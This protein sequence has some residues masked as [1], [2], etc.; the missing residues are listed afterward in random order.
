MLRRYE[1]FSILLNS[2]YTCKK[3]LSFRSQT[4]FLKFSFHVLERGE[5]VRIQLI[6]QTQTSCNFSVFSTREDLAMSKLKAEC[7]AGCESEHIMV[8]RPSKDPGG[9]LQFF[10]LQPGS[11]YEVVITSA[12]FEDY[13]APKNIGFTFSFCTS[14]W[15]F[16]IVQLKV[17][18]YEQHALF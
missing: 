2:Q 17:L 4:I 15:N 13:Y 16:F 10:S 11:A 9:W 3:G 8:N 14:K 7:L 5:G 18:K 12:I 1:K 6:E